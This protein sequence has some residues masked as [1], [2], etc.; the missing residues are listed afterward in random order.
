MI[1]E[2]VSRAHESIVGRYFEEG[3]IGFVVPDNPKVQQEVLIT[4]GRNGAAKVGQFVEVKITHWPTARFQ[5]QGDIVE[6]VGNYMAPGMEIDVALRTY[7]IPHVWPEAVLKE[8]AKLKPEVEE[9]DKESASTCAIYRSSPSMVK[10]PATSTMR[11]IAKPGLENCACS[12]AAGSCS[13]RLPTC[14]AM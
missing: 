12:P 13:S 2:V 6:V 4:P 9:K 7:D 14:P 5:P 3:G 8:A 1:V 10:T 11:S